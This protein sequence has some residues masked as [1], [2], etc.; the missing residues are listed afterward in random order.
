MATKDQLSYQPPSFDDLKIERGGTNPEGRPQPGAGNAGDQDKPRKSPAGPKTAAEKSAISK[1]NKSVGKRP[2]AKK[3]STAV[4]R[5][6]AR[7]GGMES[8][9]RV[10]RKA[11]RKKKRDS[12]GTK[13]RIH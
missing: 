2:A 4:G 8:A 12:G 13:R 3:V 9:S 10:G 11:S 6:A 1:A 5:K 7:I